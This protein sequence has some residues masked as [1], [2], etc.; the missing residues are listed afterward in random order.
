[1][2]ERWCLDV[3]YCS[4]LIYYHP[5]SVNNQ[6]LIKIVKNFHCLCCLFPL[7]CQVQCFL[8]LHILPFSP[9]LVVHFLHLYLKHLIHSSLSTYTLLIWEFPQ[10]RL[11]TPL[12]FSFFSYYFH[13]KYINSSS[14]KTDVF[15]TFL[16]DVLNNGF[17]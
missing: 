11:C 12:L 6:Q 8:S 3:L 2:R 16:L 5:L 15:V 4:H 1:M 9:L 17:Q 14:K 13:H 7:N 10:N